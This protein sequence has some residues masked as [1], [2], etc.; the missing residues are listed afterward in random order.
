MHA[1]A[2]TKPRALGIGQR[3]LRV[4]GIVVDPTRRVVDRHP[5][6]A[7]VILARER[8]GGEAVIGHQELADAPVILSR[9]AAAGGAQYEAGGMLGDRVMRRTVITHPAP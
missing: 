5:A 2:G 6:L 9:I 1:G 4:P 7:M 8:I 3:A